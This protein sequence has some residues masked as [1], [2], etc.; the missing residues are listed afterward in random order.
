MFESFTQI[1]TP[2]EYTESAV[3][4]VLFLIGLGAGSWL[5]KFI[6]GFLLL[7]LLAIPVWEI[8]NGLLSGWKDIS[9]GSAGLGL[10]IAILNQ[11]PDQIGFKALPSNKPIL[12]LISDCYIGIVLFPL[13]NAYKRIEV[14]EDKI[15]ANE[16]NRE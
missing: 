3:A 1:D 6:Y 12:N 10:I 15:K 16:N 7:V 8:A 14:L 5:G 2:L 9:L 13:S 11:L 4:V